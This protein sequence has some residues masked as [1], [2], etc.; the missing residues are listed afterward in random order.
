MFFPATSNEHPPG[1][2]PHLKRLPEVLQAVR[3]QSGG[4]G[5]SYLVLFC[6]FLE[7]SSILIFPGSPICTALV[8]QYPRMHRNGNGARCRL[9]RIGV[10]VSSL[11]DLLLSIHRRIL[12]TISILMICSHDSL[13]TGRTMTESMVYAKCDYSWCQ[14]VCPPP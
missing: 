14:H 8:P 11:F 7:I 5:L 12:S 9:D 6:F 2:M 4:D 1:T 10:Q 3:L 13:Y